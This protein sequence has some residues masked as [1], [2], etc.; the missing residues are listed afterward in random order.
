MKCF[1][2]ERG[3]SFF[4]PIQA[5]NGEIGIKAEPLEI[6]DRKFYISD[7]KYNEASFC[8]WNKNKIR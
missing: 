8:Q 6:G 3:S 4:K 2:I 1:G 5:G 7:K